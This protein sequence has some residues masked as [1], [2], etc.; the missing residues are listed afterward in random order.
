MTS[1]CPESL[2]LHAHYDR[3]TTV[4]TPLPLPTRA[5]IPGP[6]PKLASATTTQRVQ[7]AVSHHSLL[8]AYRR[9]LWPLPALDAD[10]W[11]RDE[12][13]SPA[14]LRKLLLLGT[15]SIHRMLDDL[16]DGLSPAPTES[17]TL[18]AVLQSAW[19]IQA[20][21]VAIGHRGA[22][23]PWPGAGAGPPPDLPGSWAIFVG[24]HVSTSAEHGFIRFK[25]HFDRIF[26][27]LAQ[28]GARALP[29]RPRPSLGI[30]LKR[31]L[32]TKSKDTL[33]ERRPKR[34]RRAPFGDATNQTSVSGQRLYGWDENNIIT[35]LE[36]IKPLANL[37]DDA[38]KI[39]TED[40]GSDLVL[41]APASAAVPVPSVP[42]I[43]MQ[44]GFVLNHS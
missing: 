9:S 2:Q 27:C 43:L 28:A 30:R 33:L 24:A 19:T 4:T 22:L 7:V 14:A 37:K 40:T 42:R 34:H 6:K 5:I 16:L 10:F 29:R 31:R 21:L 44:V 26:L 8:L 11:D 25:P 13:A 1:P 35:V 23:H 15:A 38:V 36:L 41:L 12:A 3:T 32:S 20:A 39:K 18:R 17:E